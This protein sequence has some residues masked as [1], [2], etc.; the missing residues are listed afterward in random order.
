MRSYVVVIILLNAVTSL[1]AIELPRNMDESDRK[2]AARILG[3]GTA[4]KLL[5]D[6]YPLGGYSG[7]ELGV[8]IESIPTDDLSRLGDKNIASQ[9]NFTYPK[10]SI[11]K[12]MYNNIDAWLHF[13]P[14]DAETGLSE[15]GGIFRWCFF[16]AK[17]FPGTFALIVHGNAA[18]VSNKL[19]SQTGGA[20]LVTGINIGNIGLY[21][22]GGKV[23][24][25]A[26]FFGGPPDVGVTD[27]G[28]DETVVVDGFH[29]VIGG[30]L[31]L[32]TLFAVVQID[33]YNQPIFSSK[34][35]LRF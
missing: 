11:G 18:N 6:P 13:I 1:A 16:Q 27:T 29:S 17:F 12:G 31:R 23:S 30:S 8:T 4:G 35:G 22:G 20:D 9:E 34:F 10:I 32:Q 21:L 33:L 15:Y 25:T 14:F 5:S 3:W 19:A 28:Y 26:R 7:L 2:Q 24:T